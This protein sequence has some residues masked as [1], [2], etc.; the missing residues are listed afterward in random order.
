MYHGAGGNS[1]EAYAWGLQESGYN[2]HGIFVYPQG[3]NYQNYGIGWDDTTKGY[4]MPFYDHMIKVVKPAGASTP[5]E[6]LPRAF[7]GAETS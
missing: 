5:S 3:I 4:D 2:E 6:A 7:R 1:A